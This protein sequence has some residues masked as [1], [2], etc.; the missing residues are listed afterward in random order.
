MESSSSGELREEP[1]PREQPSPR[2]VQ[3][4]KVCPG[5]AAPAQSGSTAGL[6]RRGPGRGSGEAFPAPRG[7]AG[8]RHME[9]PSR[10][11]ARG[12]S[13]AGSSLGSAWGALSCRPR[14]GPRCRAV[15]VPSASPRPAPGTAGGGPAVCRCG[16]AGPGGHSGAGRAGPASGR[17]GSAAAGTERPGQAGKARGQGQGQ[18]GDSPVTEPRESQSPRERNSPAGA[19]APAASRPSRALRRHRARRRRGHRDRG[20]G[21]PTCVGEAKVKAMAAGPLA[22]SA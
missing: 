15:P 16:G 6:Q 14:S 12:A 8:R 3:C 21:G 22:G 10:E 18:P 17:P 19:A 13:T 9:T 2:Q 20:G 11:W 7:T 5:Q 4:A 1:I